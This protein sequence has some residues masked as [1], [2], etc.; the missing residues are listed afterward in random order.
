VHCTACGAS[1]SDEASVC[2]RCGTE[3]AP[4]HDAASRDIAPG[5]LV[6]ASG[7]HWAFPDPVSTLLPHAQPHQRRAFWWALGVGI[8]V[9]LCW[10]GLAALFPDP[11]ITVRFMVFGAFLVPVLFVFFIASEGLAEEPP[12]VLL[13]EVFVGVALFG[14]FVAFLLNSFLPF[15]PAGAGPIEET[16]KF[17]GVIWLLRRRRYVTIMDGILFG[18]AA[19]MGF[20]ASENLSYFF[21]NYTDTGLAAVAQA[22]VLG[23]VH[24]LAG[25]EAIFNHVGWSNL[26]GVFV[27]RSVLGPW[28]HGTWT[29]I[30]AGVAWREAAGGRL[31]LDA[32]FWG[33]FILVAAMH[34]LWDVTASSGWV[35]DVLLV[36][37]VLVD[38]YLLR[39]LILQAHRQE[40]GE[41]V[42][43][44]SRTPRHCAHCGA[45]LHPGAAFCSRCGQ[46]V[47][48]TA[49]SAV[50]AGQSS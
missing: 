49:P 5:R 18:A 6:T 34:S 26:F 48:G 42:S 40:R 17:L 7:Q 12:A 20:A 24:N 31:R 33:T 10:G 14:N 38:I 47:V 3:N 9:L 28:M 15:G 11:A 19:G 22:I 44:P 35:S 25:V 32:R 30:L 16:V 8:L 36:V 39:G 43:L 46:P 21:T 2:P 37:I 23:Q 13:V 4:R 27:L 29:A 50:P 41:P 1:L 45:R